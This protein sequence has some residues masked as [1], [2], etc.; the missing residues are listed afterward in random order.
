MLNILHKKIN[1][2]ISIISIEESNSGYHIIYTDNSQ[3]NNNILTQINNILDSWPL[4]KAKLDKI[5]ELDINWKSVIN[6]GW[7]TPYGWKLGLQNADITLLTGAFLLAKEA[8][9]M[10]LSN[11]STIIDFN[12]ISR[13]LNLNDLTQLMLLYGEYRSQ[14]SS[15]YSNIQALISQAVSTQTLNNINLEI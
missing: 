3:L 8:N 10:G 6:E 1:E 7:V 12:G 2:I 14:I 13:S 9:S 11:I 5:Q 4:D 15:K